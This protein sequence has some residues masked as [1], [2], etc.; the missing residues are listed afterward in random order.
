MGLGHFPQSL[1]AS[2]GSLVLERIDRI[3]ILHRASLKL[4]NRQGVTPV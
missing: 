4:V 1:R 2:S 3:V